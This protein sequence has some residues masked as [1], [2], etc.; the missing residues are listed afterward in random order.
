M[1]MLAGKVL[2]YTNLVRFP[3]TMWMDEAFLLFSKKSQCWWVMNQMMD[4]IK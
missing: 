1:G 4:R 3:K 2:F